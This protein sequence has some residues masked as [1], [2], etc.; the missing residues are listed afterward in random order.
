MGDRRI[1]HDGIA[2]RVAGEGEAVM[3]LHGYTLDAGIW[4]ELWALLPGWTHVG[5]DLP[6]HGR[7]EPFARGET[8]AGLGERLAR[9]A[10]AHDVRHVAGLSFGGMVALAMAIARPRGF[11]SLVLASPALAGG[12]EEDSAQARNIELERLYRARGPGAWMTERWMTSPPDIFR[13]AAAHSELWARLR[14]TVERH[15]WSEL[16]DM[17]MQGLARDPQ[18][19]QDLERIEA[20]TLVLVGEDDMPAFKRIAELVRRSIPGCERVRVAGAGHLC[21]L[22]TPEEAAPLIRRHLESAQASR[23]P[24]SLQEVS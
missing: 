10:L 20:R 19:P 5:V 4:D 15:S 13:G 11:S 18:R 3:W 12:P 8:L 17:E 6:G 9:F 23:R 21:L 1:E 14:A 2:A 16:R 24:A 22:E 7:S